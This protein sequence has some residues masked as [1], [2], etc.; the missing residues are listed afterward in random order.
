MW[1]SKS[2]SQSMTFK[3]K[4]ETA[5]AIVTIAAVFVGGLW[6]YNVFIKE[7]HEYPHANIEPRLSH[8]MLSERVS[9]LQVGVE[10][11]NTGNSLMR[12]GQS[13]IRVQQVL[14]SLPCPNEGACAANEVND[15][16]KT[17][18]RQADHFSWPLIAERNNN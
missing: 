4:V 1:L 5:Q 18:E 13:V 9:L 11:T 12:I 7:R 10:L 3:E 17:I 6:T 15:A 2:P 14:P 8:V 16:I